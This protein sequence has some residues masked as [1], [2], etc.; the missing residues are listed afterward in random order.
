ME[1]KLILC[2]KVGTETNEQSD[3]SMVMTY[4]APWL[5]KNG[6][7]S[8]GT[9]EKNLPATMLVNLLKLW[10]SDENREKVEKMLKFYHPVDR[11]ALAYAL[12]IFVMTGEKMH[13][14]NKLVGHQYKCACEWLKE[15]LSGVAFANHL[16]RKLQRSCK[17]N[18]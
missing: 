12:L 16:K 9:W 15:D 10:L 11:A 8:I 4:L 7:E 1:K 2:E 3:L 18:K 13:F 5:A 14:R 17:K 6:I